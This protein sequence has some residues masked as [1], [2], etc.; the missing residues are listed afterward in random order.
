MSTSVI[1]HLSSLISSE[2][3][4]VPLCHYFLFI[5]HVLGFGYLYIYINIYR[6]IYSQ[7]AFVLLVGRKN[8]N[9]QNNYSTYFPSH[10]LKKIRV[11]IETAIKE[12]V[13]VINNICK[14][15]M[16]STTQL[17]PTFGV[18]CA[19]LPFVALHGM[20]DCTDPIITRGLNITI[21]IYYGF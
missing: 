7:I 12:K 15:N 9:K 17:I 21:V 5:L 1:D 18:V 19:E 16:K 11:T 4:H 14:C 13:A 3:I 10:S 2:S 20:A 6:C 8:P